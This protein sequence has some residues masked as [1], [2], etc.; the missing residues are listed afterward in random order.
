MQSVNNNSLQTPEQQLQEKLDLYEK[1]LAENTRYMHVVMKDILGCRI[2]DIKKTRCADMPEVLQYFSGSTPNQ[3]K[4]ALMEFLRLMPEYR[5]QNRHRMAK[6]LH[7]LKEILKQRN[8]I[9]DLLIYAKLNYDMH[10]QISMPAVQEAQV[11]QENQLNDEDFL[12]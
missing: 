9:N 12:T 4:N 2:E 6:R 1:M 5:T 3:Q 7:D 11:Q 10:N 8:E